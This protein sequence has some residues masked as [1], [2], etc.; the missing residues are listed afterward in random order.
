M[1]KDTYKLDPD[2]TQVL[3]TAITGQWF[4]KIFFGIIVD[5]LAPFVQKRTFIVIMGLLQ[6]FSCG[7][8]TIFTFGSE[9]TAT[10]FLCM[11]AFSIAF[12]DVVVSAFIV[13][14]ARKDM[15]NG[16]KDL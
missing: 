8:V 1:F 7:M 3:M 4:L 12:A 14:Y 9:Y 6:L 11:T 5:A 16:S 2:E 10:V 13:E 15:A